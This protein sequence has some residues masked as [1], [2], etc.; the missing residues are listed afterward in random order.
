M[1]QRW[2]QMNLFFQDR[3]RTVRAVAFLRKV[4][5]RDT[6]QPHRIGRRWP[7]ARVR[8]VMRWPYFSL[9]SRFDSSGRPKWWGRPCS[10]Y[11]SFFLILAVCDYVVIYLIISCRCDCVITRNLV[12]VAS[13]PSC[14]FLKLFFYDHEIFT[15]QNSFSRWNINYNEFFPSRAWIERWSKRITRCSIIYS[16]EWKLVSIVQSS[17]TNC[18]LVVPYFRICL[19]PEDGLGLQD[20][21]PKYFFSNLFISRFESLMQELEFRLRQ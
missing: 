2:E 8:C 21:P 9:C 15:N 13:V 7:V 16:R 4:P 10:H 18:D 5:R 14:V 3:R 17:W 20:A 6:S 12:T 11:P 1:R 19:V